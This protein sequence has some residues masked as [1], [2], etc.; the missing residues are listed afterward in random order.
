MNA[1][2]LQPE[3][4]NPFDEEVGIDVVD[5]NLTD[6]LS[7]LRVLLPTSQLL[8]AFLITVPFNGGFANIL[9]TEKGIF[10]ATFILSL[11][12]LVLLSAPPVQHRVIRPLIDRAR[13]KRLASRQIVVG[14]L[15]LGMALTLAT[16]LVLSTIFGHLVGI[17]FA[18]FIGGALLLL[19]WILPKA[20]R[21]KG[22]L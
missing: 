9:T 3:P 12:S 16:E 4:G 13:F 2:G 11:L 22:R 17:A 7:E 15:L 5:G 21:A 14:A 18:S 8:S 19:W 1:E 6:M 10:L 20:M